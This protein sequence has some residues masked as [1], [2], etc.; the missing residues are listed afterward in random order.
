MKLL[1]VF[2]EGSLAA[3]TRCWM[4]PVSS[5]VWIVCAQAW[6]GVV[7]MF[8]WSPALIVAGYASWL[9]F[10]FAMMAWSYWLVARYYAAIDRGEP[11][12]KRLL[13]RAV[14]SGMFP[15]LRRCS[16]VAGSVEAV[17]AAEASVRGSLVGLPGLV[18]GLLLMGG[19]LLA[20]T[21]FLNAAL[22]QRMSGL[23]GA[24]MPWLFIGAFASVVGAWHWWR[25]RRI[26]EAIGRGDW[27]CPV[28]RYDLS[29]LDELACPECGWNRR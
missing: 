11:P 14:Y 29:G 15:E 13:V 8:G 20:L 2:L 1:D 24:L 19:A 17:K 10:E 27:A 28:C 18:L 3:S 5:I 9:V 21:Q 26:R 22:S 23:L 7:F 16:T 4:L 6:T 12:R 25:V